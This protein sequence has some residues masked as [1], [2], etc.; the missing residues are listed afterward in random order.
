MANEKE[1]KHREADDITG[2][3]KPE[4]PGTPL[5]P[6]GDVTPQTGERPRENDLGEIY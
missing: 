3:P 6:G 2:T 5:A 4:A 1:K